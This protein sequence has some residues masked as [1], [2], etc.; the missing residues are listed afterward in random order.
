MNGGG[1]VH[2]IPPNGHALCE[3]TEDHPLHGA[4]EGGELVV[5]VAEARVVGVLGCHDLQIQDRLD[6]PLFIEREQ[7]R[8]LPVARGMAS[9]LVLVRGEEQGS[10]GT[11]QVGDLRE[12][13]GLQV[14]RVDVDH[15]PLHPGERL[16]VPE[17]EVHGDVH[18]GLL[19]GFVW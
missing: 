10:G 18:A 4:V 16:L 19:R 2:P 9:D 15:D 17:K 5:D 3:R 12:V 11:L 7:A 14:L 1:H 8:V 13:E 6:R